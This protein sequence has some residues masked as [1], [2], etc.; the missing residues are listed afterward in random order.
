MQSKK[1]IISHSDTTDFMSVVI[2]FQPKTF[3]TPPLA[4]FARK[5]ESVI[6]RLKLM[7]HRREVGRF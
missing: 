1:E 3:T 6:I 5:V 7:Y 4:R 2:Q